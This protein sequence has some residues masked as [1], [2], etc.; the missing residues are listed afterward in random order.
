MCGLLLIVINSQVAAVRNITVYCAFLK[1]LELWGNIVVM[2][3]C[4]FSLALFFLEDLVFG[5]H[6][7]QLQPLS[8]TTSV[9]LHRV[10]GVA[11]NFEIVSLFMAWW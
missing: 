8:L 4:L 7:A 6:Y 1:Y 5:V 3:T 9:A 2:S 10:F 11:F